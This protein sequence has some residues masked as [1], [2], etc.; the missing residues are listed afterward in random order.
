MI[1]KKILALLALASMSLA[2]LAGGGQDMTLRDQG[3]KPVLG[4]RLPAYWSSDGK[5][6]KTTLMQDQWDVH[7]QL[8]SLDNVRSVQDAV[9]MVPDLIKDEVTHF[10]ARTRKTIKVAG[11]PAEH[12]IGHG[13]EADDNDPSN[14]EVYLFTVGGKVFLLCAHGEIN[15]AA[16]ARNAIIKMLASAKRP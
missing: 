2:A 8:W 4:L 14:A 9:A 7:I 15:G 16:K 3:N 5:A 12:I 10:K 11:A 1:M 13:T 6:G